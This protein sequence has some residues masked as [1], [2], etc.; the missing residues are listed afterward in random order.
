MGNDP[1]DDLMDSSD[2]NIQQRYSCETSN[3]FEMLPIII[4]ESTILSA[5]KKSVSKPQK[6]FVKQNR[7]EVLK[8]LVGQKDFVLENVF[9]GTNILPSTYSQQKALMKL[10][11]DKKA[12]YRSRPPPGEKMKRFVLYGLNSDNYDQIEEDLLKYKIKAEKII[13]IQVKKPRYFDHCN[14]IIYIK[15][16]TRITLSVLQQAK[17]ICHTQVRWANYIVNGDG[18]TKCSNCQQFGHPADYCSLQS[19]CGIC[20][21]FHKTSNCELLLQKRAKNMSSIDPKLLKCVHCKESHTAGY[22]RCIERLNFKAKRE[23][24]ARKSTTKFVNAPTPNRNAWATSSHHRQAEDNYNNRPTNNRRSDHTVTQNDFP[25]L[26]RTHARA[27]DRDDSRWRE[28]PADQVNSNDKFNAKEIS[29]MFH[30]ILDVI[31]NC[32]SKQ[33]QMRVMIDI[34]TDYI[35]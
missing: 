23:Y 35:G 12:A 24:F 2:T 34:I 26:G 17:F 25:A 10:L 21:A 22:T 31:D 15:P 9:G 16:D 5:P 3:R 29:S 14:Y 7:T 4:P 11:D 19:R 18:V 13:K 20:A 33:E 1:P 27:A 6:I 30:K 28:K 32:N 8:L